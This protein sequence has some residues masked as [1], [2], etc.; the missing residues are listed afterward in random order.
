MAEHLGAQQPTIHR[1]WSHGGPMGPKWWSEMASLDAAVGVTTCG[2][3]VTWRPD[4]PT[5][6]GR[7]RGLGPLAE[8]AE[9]DQCESEPTHCENPNTKYEI[10]NT[11]YQIRNAN[12]KFDQIRNTDAELTKYEMR[13]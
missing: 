11:K 3:M 13:I 8:A 9:C 12:A 6:G 4:G 10:P 1:P 7:P 2:P 5:S